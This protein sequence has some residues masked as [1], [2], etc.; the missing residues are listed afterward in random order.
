M[1]QH[2]PLIESVITGQLVISV[3][4][5]NWN[6]LFSFVLVFANKHQTRVSYTREMSGKLARSWRLPREQFDTVYSRG[7]A[8]RDNRL[9]A[10][11]VFFSSTARSRQS[12]TPQFTS[13]SQ[14][15]TDRFHTARGL[16]TSSLP[17]AVERGLRS[18]I[19]HQAADSWRIRE[20]PRDIKP[21]RPTAKFTA[22][23][24]EK[25]N[26]REKE[27]VWECVSRSL[28]RTHRIEGHLGVTGEQ[29][30]FVSPKCHFAFQKYITIS[31]AQC[32]T[33][34][35]SINTKIFY[36][37]SLTCWPSEDFQNSTDV[38]LTSTAPEVQALII[39]VYCKR[40]SILSFERIM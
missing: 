34:R 19:N 5:Q 33:I 26:V 9:L 6:N 27:C 7:F 22:V 10:T 4:P 2:K 38:Q 29:M 12:R 17:G 13:L 23:H 31:I 8:R 32:Y 3:C 20:T 14:T 24:R 15:R 30:G 37:T 28:S 36:K 21:L 11:W 16:M 25:R 39:S 1:P 40:T 18:E 35:G